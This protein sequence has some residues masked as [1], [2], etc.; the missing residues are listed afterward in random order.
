VLRFEAIVHN[1]AELR[2]GRMIDKFPEI[3]TRL[4]GIAER[5]ATALDCVDTGFIGD[6][7]LD[8]LPAGSTAVDWISVDESGYL[9]V[10]GKPGWGD[11]PADIALLTE[12]NE[13]ARASAPPNR[14]PTP[15]EIAYD[16]AYEAFSDLW[17]AL[18]AQEHREYTDYAG[19]LT[20]AIQDRL[21]A[22]DLM[23]SSSRSSPRWGLVVG[24]RSL[25]RR[26]PW[27]ATSAPTPISSAPRRST[28]PTERGSRFSACCRS[29]C[30][31]RA[32]SGATSWR[33]RP[34]R[35]RATPTAG[36]RLSPA[37]RVKKWSY[38]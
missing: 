10:E 25:P 23:R 12:L 21:A 34:R 17:D 26:V 8:E 30:L 7:I 28:R 5:F 37:A 35:W 9:V 31:G 19:R 11:D 24:D 6:G 29:R 4:A 20:T 16:E 22:L 14:A 1:T 18:A 27:L 36:E 13:E 32:G 33:L 15:G 3:V 2:C 38:T